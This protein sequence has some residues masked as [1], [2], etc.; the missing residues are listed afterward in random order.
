MLSRTILVAVF[1][2]PVLG[3]TLSG[4]TLVADLDTTPGAEKES[5]PE[6]LGQ[7]A[8]GAYFCARIDS[9]QRAVVYTDGTPGNTVPLAWA[10]GSYSL[11]RAAA[12]ATL[13]SGRVVFAGDLEFSAEHALFAVGPG[14]TPVERLDLEPETSVHEGPS[15][16]V[17]WNGEVWFWA[18]TSAGGKEL[19]HTDGTAAGTLPGPELV[20]GPASGGSADSLLVVAGSKLFFTSSTPSPGV[21]CLDTPL[22]TP[23]LLATP[24]SNFSNFGAHM[25]AVGD[26]CVFRFHSATEGIEAWSSDGTVAG[27]GPLG[28]F[29]PGT[30]HSFPEFIGEASGVLFMTVDT[31][32]EGRELWT[33]DGTAAGTSLVV[34]FHPGS[35]DGFGWSGSSVWNGGV[36]AFAR[37]PDHGVE[38]TFS[39]GTPGGTYHIADLVPGVGSSLSGYGAA[40]ADAGSRAVFRAATPASGSELWATDGTELGTELIAE[41]VPGAG[42]NFIDFL[43][44]TAQGVVFLA[45]DDVTGREPWITDG[46]SAGT[47]LLAQPYP[48]AVSVG[49]EPSSQARFQDRLFFMAETP[50]FGREPW[51]TDG[52]ADGTSM[53]VDWDPGPSGSVFRPLREIGHRLLFSSGASGGA[54]DLTLIATDGTAGGTVELGTYAGHI[55]HD[56]YAWAATPIDGTTLVTI[57]EEWDDGKNF[58]FERELWW[59][60]GTPAGTAPLSEPLWPPSGSGGIGNRVGEG[61]SMVADLDTGMGSELYHTDGTPAGTVLLADV[62]PG[63]G[64]SSIRMLASSGERA[65]FSAETSGE[66]RELWSTDGT[67]AGTVLAEDIRPG[68]DS[69]L[70]SSINTALLGDVLLFPG[71]DGIAG[72]ELWRSDGTEAGT[73]LLFDVV[74]GSGSSA[75]RDLV[76]A[77]GLVYF[78]V[79]NDQGQFALW[80]T[81]GTPGRTFELLERNA[82]QGVPAGD[83]GDY[84]F[85]APDGAFGVE[86]WSSDGTPAGTQLLADLHEGP[87]SGFPTGIHRVGGRVVFAADDGVHGAELHSILLSDLGA[88][89]AEPYG[90]GC[91]AELRASGMAVLGEE[92]DLD[93][94]SSAS[95][96]GVTLVSLAPT[97]IDLGAGCSLY[98]WPPVLQLPLFTDANGEGQLPLVLPTSPEL[99]GVGVFF[100][101]V[102]QGPAPLF[103]L[104]FSNGLELQLAAP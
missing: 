6:R 10:S 100:Q 66:G 35:S 45:D 62:E 68:P 40:F 38:P 33:T 85:A 97:W 74:P 71:N 50:G 8:L 28:D 91:E 94:E 2:G 43:G 87:A 88:W 78:E 31:P 19:W 92:L 17:L 52:T 79:T 103:P 41:F 49:S 13:P 18:T 76:A 67:P 9:N 11:D 37:C 99:A 95:S 7:S 102:V 58:Y 12:Y 64:G 57:Q 23:L 48:T 80:V 56:T 16:L 26:T 21:W 51:L 86:L 30:G 25:S 5:D 15:E 60:D 93:V 89:A 3:Q 46:T 77:G 42:Y 96:P 32:A 47:S 24:A 61:W 55:S 84:L 73:G 27:T 82:F 83:G 20:P 90:Q 1:A 36:L 4:P 69:G 34:D 14:A 29:D 81:D 72:T 101:T 22:G 39:D 63:P 44:E 75:P 53:I 98:A 65:F 54:G 59:T 70:G 104:A